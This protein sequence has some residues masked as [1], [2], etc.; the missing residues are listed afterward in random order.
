[1]VII[2]TIPFEIRDLKN[3]SFDLQTIPQILG[4]QN[5]KIFCYVLITLFIF[6]SYII[7]NS[8]NDFFADLVLSVILTIIITITKE[9]QSKYFSSFWVEA[10]PIYWLVIYYLLN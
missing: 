2:Y 8:Y 10:L 9:E 6:I 3:D 7:S 5:S 1:L 4:V